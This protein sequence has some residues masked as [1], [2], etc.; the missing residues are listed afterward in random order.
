[1]TLSYIISSSLSHLVASALHPNVASAHVRDLVVSKPMLRSI[2]FRYVCGACRNQCIVNIFSMI[3]NMKS[4]LECITEVNA[5][6]L[7]HPIEVGTT[8]NRLI[9]GVHGATLMEDSKLVCVVLVCK[10]LQSK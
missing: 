5:C 6:A 3:L 4:G 1:M 10:H 8:R 7:I 9:S 2:V